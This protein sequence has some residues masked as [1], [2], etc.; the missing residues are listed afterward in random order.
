MHD[1]KHRETDFDYFSTYLTSKTDDCFTH[2]MQQSHLTHEE[3]HLIRTLSRSQDKKVVKLFERYSDMIL[4]E[5][6]DISERLRKVFSKL[7]RRADKALAKEQLKISTQN[8]E[9]LIH[10][11]NAPA[12]AF[13]GSLRQ[14]PV[15]VVSKT[16]ATTSFNQQQLES[17]F[18]M[19]Y[20]GEFLNKEKDEGALVKKLYA[21]K[22][23]ELLT[24]LS[25]YQKPSDYE[26]LK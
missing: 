13:T 2:L 16:P 8:S 17:N 6:A 5:G 23:L 18:Q 4:E 9:R 20:Y 11:S 21:E 1:L 19:I 3:Q 10:G 15:V 12:T 24:L 22:N 7:K 26:A 25:Q 14:I